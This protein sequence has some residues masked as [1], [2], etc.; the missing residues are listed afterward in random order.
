MST[1]NS[2]ILEAIQAITSVSIRARRAAE[3]RLRGRSLTFAQYGAL[4]ALSEHDG[5][6][7]AELAQALETDSTTAMVLR[8]S[9]EKKHLVD[10]KADQKDARIRR[11]GLTAEGRKL[12]AQARP[13]IANLFG[14]GASLLSEADTKKLLGMLVKLKDFVQSLIPAHESASGEKRKPGRPR[15]ASAP[16]AAASKA[17]GSK[18]APTAK[19]SKAAKVVGAK[20]AKKP[21]AKA[22]VARKAVVASAKTAKPVARKAAKR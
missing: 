19:A 7:Q 17:A 8:G 21:A 22:P 9:L 4:I 1:G 12:A 2:D 11:I 3:A 10:R 13:E 20:A 18:V 6:S 5:L 16:K 14:S 15:K